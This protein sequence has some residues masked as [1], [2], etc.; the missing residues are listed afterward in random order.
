MEPRGGGE[1][2][3]CNHEG[4]MEDTTCEPSHGAVLRGGTVLS[5]RKDRSEDL[6]SIFWTKEWS[7]E[8]PGKEISWK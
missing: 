4:F 7:C 3:V 1:E 6:V 2:G 5:D 8:V